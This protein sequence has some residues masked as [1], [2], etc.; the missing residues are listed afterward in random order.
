[1]A[2]S[3]ILPIEGEAGTLVTI[4]ETEPGALRFGLMVLAAGDI[5]DLGGLFLGRTGDPPHRL[6]RPRPAA[7]HRRLRA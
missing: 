1:M 6:A 2:G 4:T 3:V 7:D 5:G